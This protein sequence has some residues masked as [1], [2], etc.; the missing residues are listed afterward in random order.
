M[1]CSIFNVKIYEDAFSDFQLLTCAKNGETDGR[2]DG[3]ILISF[4]KGCRRA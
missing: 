3:V 1:C 2:T 4:W